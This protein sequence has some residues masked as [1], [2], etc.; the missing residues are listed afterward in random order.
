MDNENMRENE[1]INEEILEAEQETEIIDETAAEEVIADEE[2]AEEV[3]DEE[4]IIEEETD[5]TE[6]FEEEITDGEEYSDFD[7]DEDFVIEEDID[8]VEVI[9]SKKTNK[10]MWWIAAA[11]VV[12]IAVVAYCLC[13]MNGV[14]TKSIVTSESLIEGRE[15]LDVKY[16]SPV[17]ALFD[18]IVLSDAEAG[19]A[20]VNGKVIDTNFFKYVTNSSAIN[21]VYSM[22]QG[23]KIE[24][25][26]KVDWNS[27]EE[28]TGLQLIEYIKGGSI[29]SMVP[30][31]ALVNEGEKRGI[32]LTDTEKNKIKENLDQVKAQYGSEFENALKMSGFEDEAA[33][34][35]MMET[36]SLLQLVYEDFDKDPSRYIDEKAM[37]EYMKNDGKLTAKHILITP[38]SAAEDQEA[39]KADAKKKAEEVLAKVNAGE[40]FDKLVEEYNQDP[41]MT[42]KGYTFAN[43]GTMV[44]EFADAAFALEVGKVSGLVETDYGYHIIKRVERVAA[45]EDYINW[46]RDNAKVRIKKSVY[47]NVQI[48]V[49]MKELFAAGE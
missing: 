41:G 11:A 9:E 16:E 25:P 24:D 20:T 32:A 8:N 1:N 39:A 44:Q 40:D 4:K 18:K 28:T 29:E 45:V 27:A 46:L 49:D 37:A 22:M 47:D 38:D 19:I 21:Y 35:K 36:D 48:T 23:G 3:F 42:E 31:F 34:V 30:L 43:D 7:E 17:M 2:L 26:T 12:V 33:Y 5:E 15:P 13:V 14:G 10:A 6:L